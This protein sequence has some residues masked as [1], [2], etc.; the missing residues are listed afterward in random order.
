MYTVHIF[1]ILYIKVLH[2]CIH[3]KYINIKY[4]CSFNLDVVYPA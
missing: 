2:I 1:L 3:K 4:K